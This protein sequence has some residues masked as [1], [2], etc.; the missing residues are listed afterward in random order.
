M[1]QTLQGSE[2]CTASARA[3]LLMFHLLSSIFRFLGSLLHSIA[4]FVLFLT[5][6]RSCPRVE[7]DTLLGGVEVGDGC[8]GDRGM[9]S[10]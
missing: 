3:D 5:V 4:L 9:A 8:A 7:E 10:S 6:K 2:P 1:P